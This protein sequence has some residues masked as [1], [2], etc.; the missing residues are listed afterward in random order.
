MPNRLNV[1][2]SDKEVEALRRASDE[3]SCTR[4]QVVRLLIH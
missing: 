1:C 3:L 2:V 4:S